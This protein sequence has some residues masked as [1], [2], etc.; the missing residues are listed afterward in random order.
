MLTETATRA[1]ITCP[2][3]GDMIPLDK[4]SVSKFSE[5]TYFVFCPECMAYHQFTAASPNVSIASLGD[6]ITSE[7]RR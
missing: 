4:F 6:R 3:S 7:R 1:D 5:K 2:K